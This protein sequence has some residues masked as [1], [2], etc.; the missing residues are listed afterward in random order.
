MACP[1]QITNAPRSSGKELA[2]LHHAWHAVT[3]LLLLLLQ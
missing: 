2:E 1:A 3:S